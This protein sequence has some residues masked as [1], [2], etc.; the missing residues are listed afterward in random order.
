MKK[1]K[2]VLARRAHT[3]A[4]L[5]KTVRARGVLQHEHGVDLSKITWVLSGDEHVAEYQPPA[6]VVRI[7]QGWTLPELLAVGEIAAAI[8]IQVYS[9]D[10]KPL[11]PR[12]R[13]AGLETLRQ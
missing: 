4:L 9:D 3:Q 10:V 6:N 8:G 12:A 2:T 13:A 7:A 1:L 11:I 5:D